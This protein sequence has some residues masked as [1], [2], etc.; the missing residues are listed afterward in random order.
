[1]HAEREADILRACLRWLHLH[2]IYCWRQNQGAIAAVSR[3]KRRFF[4][5]AGACGVSDILGLLRPAGRFLAIEVK[6]PGGR[7]TPEQ[8][9]FLETVQANGGLALCVHSLD[10]LQAALSQRQVPDRPSVDGDV[11]R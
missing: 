9:V 1:M 10:E 2:G 8:Q 4:R 3:G 7:P 11:G 5:F 6:R